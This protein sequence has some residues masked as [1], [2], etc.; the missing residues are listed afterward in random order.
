[1]DDAF[2]KKSWMSPVATANSTSAE[3]DVVTDND[4]SLSSE[5]IVLITPLHFL[6]FSYYLRRIQNPLLSLYFYP[7]FLSVNCIHRKLIKN[8]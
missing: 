1:M 3:K 6:C 4:S 5:C 7:F 2:H 8:E